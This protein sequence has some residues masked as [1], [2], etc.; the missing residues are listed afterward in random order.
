MTSDCS[1]YRPRESCETNV[2]IDATRSRFSRRTDS[3][4]FVESG[5]YD[6]VV[7][8]EA[9]AMDGSRPEVVAAVTRDAL[10]PERAHLFLEF[11]GSTRAAWI[12]EQHGFQ[13]G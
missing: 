7:L 6:L 5:E 9:R 2:I 3:I 8:D 11:L 12:L 13:P 10:N 4:E 1:I